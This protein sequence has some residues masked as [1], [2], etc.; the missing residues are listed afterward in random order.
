MSAPAATITF[1][2]DYG[3]DDEYVGVCHGVIARRC[4]HARVIDLAHGIAP[5]DVRAGAIVLRG[6][7]PYTPGGVHL[8][9]VDP[10]VGGA[11][12]AVALSAGD[13]T[14]GAGRRLLV[15]PD[16]GLLAPAAEFLGGVRAAVAL[17]RSPERLEPVSATFH[18]R[19]VFAPVAAALAAG[20]DFADVGEPIDPAGLCALELSVARADGAGLVAHVV[21][22][23]RFGNLMLDAT[24]AQLDEV[25]IAPGTAVA[26]GERDGARSARRGATF[27]DVGGGD[28][29][30][31]LDGLGMVALAVNGGSARKLLAAERGDTLRL[32]AADPR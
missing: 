31:Y 25:G 10:G 13:D 4:P 19:D 30:L 16:N 7:L 24:G 15:G 11:R 26:V 8:A 12:R 3:L 22:H 27:S 29:L 28:L 6:A 17:D 23:D 21:H 2:S 9:V 5:G 18:G 32:A 1:L 14:E 20:A